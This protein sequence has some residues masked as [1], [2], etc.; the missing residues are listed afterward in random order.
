MNIVKL[1]LHVVC[2]AQE[3][4]IVFELGLGILIFGEVSIEFLTSSLLY[5]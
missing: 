4:F 1:E 2:A 3:K 5:M